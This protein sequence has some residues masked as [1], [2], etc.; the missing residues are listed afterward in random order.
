MVNDFLNTVSKTE[1]EI[2]ALLAKK[3]RQAVSLAYKHYGANLY[4][5]VL[6]IVGNENDAQ[7][8][9]QDTFVKIWKNAGKYDATKGRLFTWM[10]NIARRTAIDKTRGAQYKATKRTDSM[11][12]ERNFENEWGKSDRIVDVGLRKVVDSLDPKYQRII[13][14]I[15]YQGY[16]QTE[17][18][19]ELDIPLGTVKSRVRLA[20]NELR[21]IL[22][23][24]K[25][26]GHFAVIVGM[27][28]KLSEGL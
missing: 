10:I 25:N 12:G 20:M 6:R 5:V 2:V 28:K 16:T 1:H 19:K 15:Y 27:I 17:V 14:L 21:K 13:D 26:G 22:A 7:E 18:Q 23:D 24:P 9:I 8:V 3:D 4:G 11:D